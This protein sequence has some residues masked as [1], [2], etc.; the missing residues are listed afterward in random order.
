M[1]KRKRRWRI[2][3][4]TAAI[5]F[6]IGAIIYWYIATEKF[7]DTSTRK[8]HYT[9]NAL[10]FIKEFE[11]D[12]LS[13]NRKYAD[14]II[15]VSGRVSEVEPADTA[16]NVKFVDT[17]SGSYIIFAFQEK[18][19]PDAKTLNEGDSVFIKGSFSS[20]LFS[21]ILGT[22]FITFKRSALNN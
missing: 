1:E 10:D 21:E 7:A 13:A 22:T 6:V 20:G 18:H 2:L 3:F 19:I 16:V 9:V 5:F 17:T 14:K 4:I 15:T 8:P 11:K 12:Y